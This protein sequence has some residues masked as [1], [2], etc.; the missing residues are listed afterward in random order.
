LTLLGFML[1]PPASSATNE[2][3]TAPT[4]FDRIRLFDRSLDL[5]CVAGLDGYLKQVN[6][7]W[8]RV[9]GWTGQEL[10]SRPVA[11]FVHPDDR[12]RTLQARTAL[13]NGVPISGLENRYVCKDGSYRWLSWQSVFEP[14][15]ATVF[16]VARDIT[17]QRQADYER[18]ILSKLES[19]GVLASGIAH[20]F[21]N[22]LT[23]ILLNLEMIGMS[24]ET[25]EQ[26]R[27]C[28]RQAEQA[29]QAAK[30]ITKQLL[31]FSRGDV[32]T[33]RAADLTELLQH[34]C[35]LA[36]SGSNSRSEC[37]LPP[38]LWPA[39]VDEAQ[40][41]HMVRNLV[42]NA[43]E[44]MPTGGRVRIEARNVVLNAPPR[45]GMSSGRYV[46]IR[47]TDEGEG[48]APEVLPRIFDPYFSTKQRGSQ[49]GMGLGLTI[50]HS[51]VKNHGGMITVD[52]ERRRGTTVTFV[53]PAAEVVAAHSESGPERIVGVSRRVLVMDDEALI[54]EI[55]A[56]AFE[57]LG[58]EAVL[59]A[60]GAE[61]IARY[62]EARAI[63]DPFC[64]VLLD[65][66]VRGGMGGLEAMR[67]LQ[68]VDPGVQAV[69]M[70][71]QTNEPAFLNHAQL[72]FRAALTKPFAM[73]DLRAI[74]AGMTL[75]ETVGRT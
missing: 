19:T 39:D 14:G 16:G 1:A 67:R 57:Q 40:I 46:E 59:V 3:S 2:E 41:A 61:A 68:A 20:D 52:T 7:A 29:I 49:K 5:L 71:G 23:S 36:L 44:A 74:F 9:L 28:M 56:R 24:G 45:P 51:V 22:L 47:V 58:C 27:R 6:P 31:T 34:S 72:G 32:M 25:N 26:Q 13:A 69:L 65:L 33:R 21:N 38:D 17:E 70:T 15:A 48:I 8:T 30:G 50:C 66:T 4:E 64:V 53:L 11:D 35:A 55:L 42:L 12:E 54:R 73:E 37:V 10:L 18:L 75:T 63:G 62:E 43:R 60:E